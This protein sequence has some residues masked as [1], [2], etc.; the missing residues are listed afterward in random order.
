MSFAL[1]DQGIRASRPRVARLMQKHHIK[2]IVRRKYRVQTT[3]SQHAF[4][5]ANNYLNR[6]FAAEK[7][8]EKW[9]SDLT[10]LRTGEG[11]LYLTAILDPADRKVVGWALCE[12]MEAEETTVA[13]FRMAVRNRPLSGTLLFHSDRG[14]QYAC[15]AFRQQL[16]GIPV[17]QSMSRKGNCWDNAVAESFFKTLKTELVYHYK[18]STRQEARLAVFEYIEGFYNRERRH[19]ALGYLTPSQYEERLYKQRVAA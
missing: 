6:D 16:E 14:V 5:V 18:F 15:S 4:I 7:P 2:S 1:R 19:S 9:V 12:T 10:C 11:W 3:D 13:A 8:G 17:V